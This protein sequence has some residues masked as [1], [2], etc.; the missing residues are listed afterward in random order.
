MHIF[1]TLSRAED[2][3]KVSFLSLAYAD[4]KHWTTNFILKEQKSFLQI[5]D[6]EITKKMISHIWK[7]NQKY[8][9]FNSMTTISAD[10]I[11][12]IESIGTMHKTKIKNNTTQRY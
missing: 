6:N 10:F 9:I 5:G 4:F 12:A 7:I 11:N 1:T 2:R 3:N 8:H